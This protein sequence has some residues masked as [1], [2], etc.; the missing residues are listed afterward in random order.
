MS[1]TA[2]AAASDR[3]PGPIGHRAAA[4]DQWPPPGAARQLPLLRRWLRDRLPPD[5]EA[6]ARATER[7]WRLLAE[8]PHGREPTRRG[9]APLVVLRDRA[10][11]ALA[12]TQ[13]TAPAGSARIEQWVGP[14]RLGAYERA[15]STLPPHERE[16]LVLRIEFAM[17]DAAV[18]EE[19]GTC[20]ARVREIAANGLAALVIAL[21]TA[22]RR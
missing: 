20:E 8:P 9:L 18:A 19:I 11:A 15:L 10:L 21:A 2:A 17:S 13:P 3:P 14:E 1:R 4:N 22:A 12:R 5:R 16:V 6:L 7:V